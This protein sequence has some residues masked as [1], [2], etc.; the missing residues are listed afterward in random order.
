MY[1]ILNWNTALTEKRNTALTKTEKENNLSKILQFIKKFLDGK[2]T[3]AVL[4]QIP[5]K[6][7]NEDGSWIYSDS[8]KKFETEF[9]SDE[10]K[11]ISNNDFNDGFIVMQTV[12]VTRIKTFPPKDNNIY[13]KGEPTNREVAIE[14]ENAFSLLG[15]HA[16]NGEKNL[17]YIKSIKGIADVIVGDFN[18][19]DYQKNT[20]WETFRKIL[21][22]HVC[23]CNLPTKCVVD[24]NG[25]L[26]RKTCIDHIFI[27][28]ELIT[29]CENVKVHD[30]INYSDHYPITFDIKL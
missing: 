16:E 5:F 27:K 26:I 17:T 20:H 14:I 18:A 12:I 15:L 7:K 10:Y 24:E 13:T 8:Y 2:N 21:P 11:I 22:S 3:I 19:G 25:K 4:Q 9:S 29:K 1:Q 6:M 30:N 28:R 23:V